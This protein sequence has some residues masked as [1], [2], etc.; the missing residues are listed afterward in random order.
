MAWRQHFL[1]RRR[2]GGYAHLGAADWG[3]DI[4][5]D[6]ASQAHE[7]W[8]GPGAADLNRSPREAVIRKL[9]SELGYLEPAA[10]SEPGQSERKAEAGHQRRPHRATAVDRGQWLEN[11]LLVGQIGGAGCLGRRSEW[12]DI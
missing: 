9:A 10:R 7:R 3:G 5:G 8:E 6:R 1:F 2:R 12:G 4:E 11:G